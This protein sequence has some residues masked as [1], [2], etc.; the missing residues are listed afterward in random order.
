MIEFSVLDNILLFLAITNT[1]LNMFVLFCNLRAQENYIATPY[2]GFDLIFAVIQHLVSLPNSK[3]PEKCY[4][5][6]VLPIKSVLL[7]SN[8][9]IHFVFN[10]LWSLSDTFYL[11]MSK[12]DEQ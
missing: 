4:S 5:V 1:K 7:T 2:W 3:L 9:I 6:N 10:R 11:K 8:R 12:A